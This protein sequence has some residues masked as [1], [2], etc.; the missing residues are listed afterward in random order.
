MELTEL[1]NIPT[2]RPLSM[3][4]LRLLD[5]TNSMT[6]IAVDSLRG[7]LRRKKHVPLRLEIIPEPSDHLKSTP[8]KAKQR[9]STCTPWETSSTES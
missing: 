6:L 3:F 2:L 4:M 1:L 7:T 8:I 5:S 9:R